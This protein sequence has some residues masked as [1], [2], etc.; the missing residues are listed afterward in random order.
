MKKIEN[1]ICPITYEPLEKNHRYSNKGLKQL[2]QK[3]HTLNDLPFS[4]EQQR[5]EA[6]L[7][8]DKMS[9]QGVQLKLCAKID[10]QNQNFKICDNG[11]NYILKPQSEFYSELPE[12]EDLSMRLA[13]GI[14]EIPIHGLIYSLDGSLTYFIKRF[15][16]LPY[17]NKLAVEDFSQL[18]GLSRETKYEF[19]MEKI[20]PLIERFCTFPAIEKV[21]LFQR[22]IFNFLIGNE[23]MHVKNFSLITRKNIVELAPGYDFINTTLA[24]EY[25]KEEI[26]L[27]LHGKKNNLTRKDLIEYYGIERLGINSLLINELLDQF[28]KQIPRWKKLIEISFLSEK[29]KERYQFLLAERFDRLK[30]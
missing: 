24:L 8:S 17:H 13:E 1:P 18:A 12:N 22:V 14:I 4:A 28:K 19:S 20:I 15:D 6:Q 23:D 25:A 11:G 7:R 26:A 16:R 3:L 9:I 27:S 30:I 10:T 2:S 5:K 29:S 21:K